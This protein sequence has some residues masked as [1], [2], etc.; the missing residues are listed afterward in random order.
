MII[1]AGL[2]GLDLGSEIVGGLGR[3]RTQ[4]LLG[5]PELSENVHNA[6]V[7]L[8]ESR[9]PKKRLTPDFHITDES[10]AI[11][12]LVVLTLSDLGYHTPPFIQHVLD[13]AYLAEWSEDVL[14]GQSVELGIHGY[15]KLLYGQGSIATGFKLRKRV[16]QF[17]EKDHQPSSFT[18]IDMI[19][20]GIGDV[21][22]CQ[23]DHESPLHLNAEFV[24]VLREKGDE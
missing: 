7:T 5:M 14:D 8:I 18:P 20:G 13:P 6:V 22:T 3:F 4:R 17:S 1:S 12:F 21:V 23:Y 11:I 10:G 9:V 15:A 24:F 16:I 19:D 2:K